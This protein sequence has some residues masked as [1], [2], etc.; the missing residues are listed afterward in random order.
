M[1]ACTG[2][3]A[4]ATCWCDACPESH[5]ARLF[6][7]WRARLRCIGSDQPLIDDIAPRNLLSETRQFLQRQFQRLI[8]FREAETHDAGFGGLPVKG[9][10]R[11]RRNADFGG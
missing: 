11:D 10:N 1:P 2:M 8:L 4:F 9:G 3:L 5:A 6:A 7:S